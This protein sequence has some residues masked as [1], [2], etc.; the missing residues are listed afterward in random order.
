MELSMSGVG[1]FLEK[2]KGE[3]ETVVKF[4][5]DHSHDQKNG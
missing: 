1:E 3:L 4:W 5:C 2:F